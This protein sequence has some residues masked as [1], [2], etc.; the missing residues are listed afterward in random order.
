M[1]LIYG[2]E[3]A[4][5]QRSPEERLECM[6]QH[7]ELKDSM[8]KAGV[9][10]AA[11]PLQPTATA[12]TIRVQGGK[13][14]VTD[15]PFAE[16]KEQLGGYYLLECKNLDEAIAWTSKLASTCGGAWGSVEIRPL[17]EIAQ[18][19]DQIRQTLAKAV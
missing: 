15:G 13:P 9:F 4:S 18:M 2:N 10:L 8:T 7:F 3:T 5:A 16:T 12:T 11:D 6:N 14:I 1:L 17:L 19:Q